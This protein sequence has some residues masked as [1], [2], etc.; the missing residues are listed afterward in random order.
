MDPNKFVQ[1]LGECF[2][3]IFYC[4]KMNKQHKLNRVT[5]YGITPAQ[6]ECFY[7]CKKKN[8]K[9]KSWGK[10]SSKEMNVLKRVAKQKGWC[11]EKF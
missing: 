2:W 1:N 5:K 3:V 7:I 8:V 9:N 11:C 4:R 10:P 6:Y